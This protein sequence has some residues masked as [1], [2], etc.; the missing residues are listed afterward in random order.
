MATVREVLVGRH[1]GASI[2]LKM[3]MNIVCP[4]C[5]MKGQHAPSG[6]PKGQQHYKAVH[7]IWTQMLASDELL[8]K[9]FMASQG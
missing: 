8:F 7:D 9:M 2:A 1:D 3:W 5:G 6:S 4:I